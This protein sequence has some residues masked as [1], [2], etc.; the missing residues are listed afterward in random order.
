MHRKVSAQT[1]RILLAFLLAVMASSML[2]GPLHAEPELVDSTPPDGAVLVEP[3]ASVRLCWSEPVR[4]EEEEDWD[5]SVVPPGGQPLGLRI[6]F[7]A[8]G[9]CVDLIPGVPAGSSEGI[10][11]VDWFVRARSDS[12]EKSGVVRFQVGDLQ[13]GETALPVPQ[14]TSGGG[15][16]D[17]APIALIALAAVGAAIVALSV[18]VFATRRLRR[19]GGSGT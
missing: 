3:P 18:G 16:D 10:W 6:L 8:E 12:S 11:N 2:P 13:P 5:F 14:E 7:A 17:G 19:R 1:S 15:D 4:Q 9:T